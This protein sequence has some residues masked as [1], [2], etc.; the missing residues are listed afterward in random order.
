MSKLLTQEPPL[1]VLPSLAA[2]IGLNE[3]IM[4]HRIHYWTQRTTNVEPDND[5]VERAW[6]YRTPQGWQTDF[7]FWSKLTIGRTLKS[8][9]DDG[10]I[11]AEQRRVH[12]VDQTYWYA[13][14]Y[15]ALPPAYIEN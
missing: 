1:Q 9:R 8:L 2:E 12:E 5:G 6:M 10:I 11:V 7:P 4:L 15:D 13:V 14:D 3:A